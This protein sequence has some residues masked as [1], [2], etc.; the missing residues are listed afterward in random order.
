MNN[1]IYYVENGLNM[2]V[3]NRYLVA[4]MD[5]LLVGGHIVGLVT[6]LVPLVQYVILEHKGSIK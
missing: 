1:V 2:C 3:C 4:V 6:V 5:N